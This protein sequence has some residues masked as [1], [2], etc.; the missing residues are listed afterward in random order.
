MLINIW[1]TPRTGSNW[2]SFFLKNQ[3]SSRYK[4]VVFLSEPF[5]PYHH[6]MYYE[7]KLNG[8]LV[9]HSSYSEGLFWLD[10]KL[11]EKNN[12]SA[13]KKYEINTLDWHSMVRNRKNLILEKNDEN[14]VVMHNH[15]SPLDEDIFL[16]LINQATHNYYT[17]RKDKRNQLASY[18]LAY[19]TKNFIKFSGDTNEGQYSHIVKRE[20]LEDLCLRITESEKRMQ[21]VLKYLKIAY[22]D[23]SFVDFPS[24]PVKQFKNSWEQ[25]QSEDKTII[26]ELLLAHKLVL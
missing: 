4:N 8:E 1:S 18:A 24:A 11:D 25:L 14:I 13:E 9:N 22:E 7:L 26:D 20:V 10:Y 16:L 5:N 12:I 17:Y 23:M 19:H 6:K 2:L 21:S 15:V 3:L